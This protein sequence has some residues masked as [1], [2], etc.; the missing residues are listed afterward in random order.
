MRVLVIT[1]ALGVYLL[2]L[3]DLTTTHM[4]LNLGAT[5]ANRY[6][7]TMAGTFGGVLLKVLGVG[8]LLTVS[9]WLGVRHAPRMTATVYAV[10]V[11]SYLYVVVSNA[12]V[13]GTLA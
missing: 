12:Y 2:G 1:L 4:G 5:E 9:T 11:V 3:A 10:A 7:A 6:M 8:L 13:I